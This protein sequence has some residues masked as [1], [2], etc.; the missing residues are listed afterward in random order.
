[1]AINKLYNLQISSIPLKD[2]L[3]KLNRN[4]FFLH[5]FRNIFDI[6]YIISFKLCEYCKLVINFVVNLCE[7]FYKK[8]ASGLCEFCFGAVKHF[9]CLCFVRQFF[10]SEWNWY[11]WLV[12]SQSFGTKSGNYWC[13]EWT[14]CCMKLKFSLDYKY[15]QLAMLALI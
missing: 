4:F 13:I 14:R 8:I 9:C 6:F 2:F 7:N 15:F 12:F 1:M 10:G 5:I 11:E 3:K